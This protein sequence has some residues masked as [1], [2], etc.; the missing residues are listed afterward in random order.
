[1]LTI[2]LLNQSL[3]YS[4]LY[5]ISRFNSVILKAQTNSIHTMSFHSINSFHSELSHSSTHESDSL[6]HDLPNSSISSI[7]GTDRNHSLPLALNISDL[8]TSNILLMQTQMLH[9]MQT[10]AANSQHQTVDII[11]SL[12]LSAVEA[13]AQNLQMTQLM[14]INT[15]AVCGSKPVQF[16]S[17]TDPFLVLV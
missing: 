14:A 9:S 16:L 1:M 3:L 4:S 7:H 17:S 12:Q 13:S 11:R 6:P 2:T 15:A 5:Y 10:M 8:N